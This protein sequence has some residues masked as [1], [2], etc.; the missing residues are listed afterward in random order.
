[1]TTVKTLI[2]YDKSGGIIASYNAVGTTAPV[3]VPYIVVDLPE[4]MVVQSV[5]VKS[6]TPIYAKDNLVIS[7]IDKMNSKMDYIAMMNGIDIN[8]VMD[9]GS[10]TNSTLSV[11]DDTHS[12]HYYKVLNYYLT[13]LWSLLAVRYAVDKNW[14]SAEEFATIVKAKN[15]ADATLDTENEIPTV[16]V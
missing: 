10:Y 2:I 14:I 13:D 12:E 7:E 4:G 8:A 1:M 16:T 3:G 11:N 15:E 6:G 9:A 5:D